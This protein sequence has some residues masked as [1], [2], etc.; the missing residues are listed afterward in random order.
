MKQREMNFIRSTARGILRAMDA[1][2]ADEKGAL[3]EALAEMTAPVDR[4]T[5]EQVGF[6]AV[7][8]LAGHNWE[9]PEKRS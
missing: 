7:M 8:Y 3:I 6:Y 5:S 2:Q 4:L 9:I 1:L